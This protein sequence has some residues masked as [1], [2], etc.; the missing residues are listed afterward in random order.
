MLYN[1]NNENTL[2]T[3][4]A[5]TLVPIVIVTIKFHCIELKGAESL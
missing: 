1:N 4:I 5:T 2:N 3:K